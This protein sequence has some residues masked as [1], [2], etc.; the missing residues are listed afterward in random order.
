MIKPFLRRN[1]LRA[2]YQLTIT[3]LPITLLWLIIYQLINYP[4]TFLIKG[5]LLVPIICLLTL[6][7]SRTFS[8]MHDCGH[9]SLFTKRQLNRF[10]VF[11]L[12]LVSEIPQKSWSIDHAFHNRNNGN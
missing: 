8:L 1:N 3:I 4:F 2:L 9:N 5:L 12:G 6:L 11:L 10:F 7:S